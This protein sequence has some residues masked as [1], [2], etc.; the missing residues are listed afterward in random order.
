MLSAPQSKLPD[1]RL[2]V[3]AKIQADKA[4]ATAAKAADA[5]ADADATG[6]AAPGAGAPR[7]TQVRRLVHAASTSTGATIFVS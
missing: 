7:K 3:L 4:A 5:D 1:N 6:T 2:A